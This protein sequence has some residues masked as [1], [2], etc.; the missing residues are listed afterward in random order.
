VS[1][2]ITIAERNAINNTFC[3]FFNQGGNPDVSKINIY[4]DATARPASADNAVPN[5]SVLL[6]Q[7]SFQATAFPASSSGTVTANG[8]PFSSS[9]LQTGTAS[10]FRPFTGANSP[11]SL[12]DGAITQT[13]TSP[14]G[15]MVFDNISFIS[16]GIVNLSTFNITVPSL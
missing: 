2:H 15:E 13:G 9:I 5:G 6:A 3:G 14:S 4:S 8:L 16:G 1:Y 7:L 11:A 10:W 12:G